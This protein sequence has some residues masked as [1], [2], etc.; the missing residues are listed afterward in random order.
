MDDFLM[1]PP[2]LGI[3][4]ALCLFGFFLGVG[5]AFYPLPIALCVGFGLVVTLAILAA[6]RFDTH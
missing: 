1:S 4:A 6:R 3:V 2:G 5:T